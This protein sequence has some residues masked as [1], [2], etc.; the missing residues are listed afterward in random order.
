MK[1][2]KMKMKIIKDGNRPKDVKCRFDDAA[3]YVPR[4][5]RVYTTYTP[6][7]R[8]YDTV[9][10]SDV[11]IY[12]GNT[13]QGKSSNSKFLRKPTNTTNITRSTSRKSVR[14]QVIR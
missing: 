5:E 4:G 8:S 1:K 7:S 6:R 3:D 12:Q 2:M 13:R 11:L 10:G 9:H 14:N